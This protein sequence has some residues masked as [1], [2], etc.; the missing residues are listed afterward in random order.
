[1][2]LTPYTGEAMLVVEGKQG[3][4][5]AMWT[6]YPLDDPDDTDTFDDQSEAMNAA[7]RLANASNRDYQVTDGNH[8]FTIE[9]E[10]S[11]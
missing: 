6:I 5:I 4:D 1:M 10:E 9:S 3:K 8:L 11:E 2:V 7:D